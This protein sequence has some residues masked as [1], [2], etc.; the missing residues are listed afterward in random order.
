MSWRGVA[1]VVI[2]LGGHT[3]RRGGALVVVRFR[4]GVEGHGSPGDAC[5]GDGW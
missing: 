1:L 4:G 2:S 3:G 5:G